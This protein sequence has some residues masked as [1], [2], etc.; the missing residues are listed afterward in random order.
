MTVYL[1]VKNARSYDTPMDL[2]PDGNMVSF[3]FGDQF[4]I[5]LQVECQAVFVHEGID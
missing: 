3:I 2:R 5:V 1:H 4:G